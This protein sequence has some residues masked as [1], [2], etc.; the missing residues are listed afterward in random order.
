MFLPA[1]YNSQ[2]T[3][4]PKMDKRSDWSKMFYP[5]LVL[6]VSYVDHRLTGLEQTS[7]I[8]QTTKRISKKVAVEGYWQRQTVDDH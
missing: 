5:C 6:G 8:K 3:G 7:N 2:A 1:S 4:V